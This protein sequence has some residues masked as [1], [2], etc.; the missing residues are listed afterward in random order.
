[1]PYDTTISPKRRP[2]AIDVAELAG[3]SQSTVSRTFSNPGQI[4]EPT[5]ARVIAAAEKLE[6]QVDILGSRLR[7]SKVGVI[8]VV[9]IG[10]AGVPEKEVNP[11]HYSLLGSICSAASEA[12][13]DTL[14]SFQKEAFHGH[15][16][17]RRQADGVI[18]IGTTDN[19]EGWQHFR[20]LGESNERIACWGSPFDDMQWVRSDNADGARQAVRHL[21]ASGYRNIVC[22]GATDS[23][24]RQFLERYD[25]YC[26]AM[27][28]AG[29]NPVLHPI[30]AALDREE[31]GRRG[32]Q[33]LLA[34]DQPVDAIFAACDAIAL[35]VLEALDTAG[36][37]VPDEIGVI[38]FDGIYAA[39]FSH[40][41]LTTLA[42]D[43]TQAGI[44]LVARIR[45]LV[46]GE[47]PPSPR[48]PVK[49]LV[50]QSTR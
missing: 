18:V 25:G 29:L 15:Y 45:A 19:R 8:A 40:P 7:S 3:V 50:R 4:S 33:T 14:V 20:K 11:F 37:K 42:P 9:V 17:E 41:P 16:F 36:K 43:L 38:G 39:R 23:P 49:L 2:T 1:M 21:I 12:G 32:V 31:Q 24:Q 48:I 5:R 34:G 47:Q 44:A 28:E 26:A 35:G 22:L 6:Y 13:Y 46:E 10:R 30:S 27:T